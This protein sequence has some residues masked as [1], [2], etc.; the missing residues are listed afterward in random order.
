M[1]AAKKRGLGISPTNQKRL[2]ISQLRAQGLLPSPA[3]PSRPLFSLKSFL[4][5][6]L[7]RLRIIASTLS[8]GSLVQAALTRY[9]QT[10]AVIQPTKHGGRAPTRTNQG[11]VSVER[12]AF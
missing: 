9:L 10:L 7:A 11:L 3:P 4:L 1:A 12:H 6:S 5:G 8:R 2:P